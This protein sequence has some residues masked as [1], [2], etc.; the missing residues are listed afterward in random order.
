MPSAALPCPVSCAGYVP[1]GPSADRASGTCVGAVVDVLGR[2]EPV[3]TGQPLAM[4]R[5]GWGLRVLRGLVDLPLRRGGCRC[6]HHLDPANWLERQPRTWPKVPRLAAP[7]P[8][9]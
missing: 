7:R 2:A 3:G 6:R 5:R 1:L 4:G 9:L 8:R